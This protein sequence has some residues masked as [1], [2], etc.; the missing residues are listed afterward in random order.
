MRRRRRRR[1]LCSTTRKIYGFGKGVGFRIVKRVRRRTPTHPDIPTID[2]PAQQNDLVAHIRIGPYN[3]HNNV[4]RHG[5]FGDGR[6]GEM[7]NG[8]GE[9]GGVGGGGGGGGAVAGVQAGEVVSVFSG[10]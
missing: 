9:G 4:T 6:H 2:V 1:H 5:G 7:D 3:I 10:D 8:R